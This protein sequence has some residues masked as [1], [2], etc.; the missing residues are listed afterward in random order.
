MPKVAVVMAVY[1]GERYLQEAVESILKQTFADFEFLVVDDGSTDR[2]PAILQEFAERD[3][4]IRVLQNAEN[5]GLTKSL[6]RGI[7]ASQGEYIARMDADDISHPDR[8]KRQIVFL[9]EHPG[10][11]LVGSWYVKIDEQGRELW[12]EELPT[13]DQELRKNL[14]VRNPL[15]HASLMMRR[16][17]LERVGLYDE[18]W[19]VSQDYELLFRL[20]HEY[21]IGAVPEVLFFSR[22]SRVS[23]TSTRNREQ[24]LAALRARAAAIQ[25]RQYPKHAYLFCLLALC[26]F[27]LPIS[28]RH[29]LKRLI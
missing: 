17:A 7:R 6:N 9:H 13:E 15:P 25:R 24:I 19:Q 14:I 8:F 22:T 26:S 28:W 27:F 1:N 29:F 3:T 20:S 4:R 5:L 10:H 2:T 16:Q 21:E 23:V 11:G 12:R 18:R